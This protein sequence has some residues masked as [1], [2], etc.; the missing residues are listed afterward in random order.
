MIYFNKLLRH[1][2]TLLILYHFRVTNNLIHNIN[3]KR[4]KHAP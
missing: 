3:H 2:Y 1:I 4:E